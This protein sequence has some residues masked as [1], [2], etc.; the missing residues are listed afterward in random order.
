MAARRSRSTRSLTA[1]WLSHGARLAGRAVV[2]HLLY[3][4][5][6]PEGV[7]FRCI[8]RRGQPGLDR[9]PEPCGS[10]AKLFHALSRVQAPQNQADTDERI[11]IAA[12]FGLTTGMVN[13]TSGLVNA[14]AQ[15]SDG[16]N[17]GL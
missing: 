2:G 4:K 9:L 1:D 11:N 16:R 3:C 15:R 5:I 7:R 14:D 6:S 8:S 10:S 12:I 17:S 13:R